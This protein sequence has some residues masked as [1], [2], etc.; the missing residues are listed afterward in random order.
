MQTTTE[1]LQIR[2]LESEKL[3][4]KIAGLPLFQYAAS[5]DHFFEYGRCQ[6]RTLKQLEALKEQ[7]QQMYSLTNIEGKRAIFHQLRKLSHRISCIKSDG[8]R[9]G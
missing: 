8:R 4:I 2:E 6:L 7:Y 1:N 9:F 3:L 5:A